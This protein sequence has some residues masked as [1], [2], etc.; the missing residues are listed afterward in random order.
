MEF[1]RETGPDTLINCLAIN[2]RWWDPEAKRWVN[3]A[4]MERQRQFLAKLMKRCSHSYEK[5]S[6]V[7]RGIQIILNS[8]AWELESHEG[9]YR[10]VKEQMGLSQED[11]TELGVILNTCMSPWIRSQ[12]TFQR[13]SIIIRNELYNAYGA[14]RE[15][16]E[17]DLVVYS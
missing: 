15:L 12:K 17:V 3:N 6:M 10:A 2:F 16:F 4:S 11:Q 8:S 9:V 1:L 13:I 5:P 7:D 14:V